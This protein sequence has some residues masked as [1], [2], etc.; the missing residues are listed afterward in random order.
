MRT[1]A[2]VG[3]VALGVCCDM[4]VFEVGNEFVFVCLSA[5]AEE[6]QGIGFADA[7]AHEL[8]LL[9]N[10]FL[11]LL[12]NL[13]EVGIAQLH[14]LGWHHVVVESVFD[15]WSDSEL[16]TRVQLLECFGH[17]VSRCVPEGMLCFRGIPFVKYYGCIVLYRAVQFYCF[18]VYATCQHFG[19]EARADA[20]GN[21]LSRYASFIRANAA[22]GKC[23]LYH[24]FLHYLVGLYV[25][26][27]VQS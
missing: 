1:T 5:V 7:F 21:L 4:A 11:H 27:A 13:R 20:L 12:F 14:S 26:K 18:S 10:Q 15:G 17:E 25:H 22:V 23:N 19:G 8:F 6:L 9:G 16:H 3:E 2:E 24:I